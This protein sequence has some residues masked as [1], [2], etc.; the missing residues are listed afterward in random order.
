[1]AA[2]ERPRIGFV[3]AGNPQHN[4]DHARSIGLHALLPLVR[5]ARGRFI[6]LQRD[7]RVG[8]AEIIRA[9]PAITHIGDELASF[10]DTA[11]VIS[12][13]DLVITVDTAVA[14]LAGALGKPLW[15]LL[16][17]N[18]DWRW[19]LNRSD[20]PWYPTARLFRQLR[21]DDWESVIAEVGR[22]LQHDL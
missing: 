5:S 7:L 19:Q 18:P 13:L 2:M 6:S 20:S 12:M 15:L 14:H 17:S 8:D 16:A 10:G 11:A 21:A 9:E 1:M 22:T 4:N 3:W